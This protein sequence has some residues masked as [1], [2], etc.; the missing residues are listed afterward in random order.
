VHADSGLQRYRERAEA[1]EH[2]ANVTAG[3]IGKKELGGRDWTSSGSRRDPDGSSQESIIGM[4][5]DHVD[6]INQGKS[7]VFVTRTVIVR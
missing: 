2:R 1:G 6:F 7:G 3:S 4:S 5:P